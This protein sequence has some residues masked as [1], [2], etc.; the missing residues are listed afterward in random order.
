N[1][2]LLRHYIGNLKR[3]R[4]PDQRPTYFLDV[5][6]LQTKYNEFNRPRVPQDIAEV[7]ARNYYNAIERAKHTEFV[8]CDDIGV[9]DATEGFRADLHSIIDHRVANRKP[10][11]Y[12]SNLPIAELP[13]VFG[14]QRLA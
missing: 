5:N 4:T 13:T 7:A 11:V 9:R 14:E 8:V 3:K 10:T 2:Y 12:T 1:E 6:K